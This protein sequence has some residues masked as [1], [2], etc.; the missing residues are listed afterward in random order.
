MTRYTR[1]PVL[2]RTVLASTISALMAGGAA[3]AQQPA[4]AA[5][6]ANVEEITVTGSRILRRDLNAPTPIM[7]VDAARLENSSTLS[8]E[9]VLNQMPQFVPE[10]TQFDQGIQA[11][12][13]ASLGIGSVNLRGIGAN[14]SLVLIDGRRA[15]PA[16]AALLVDTNSI[17]AAAIERVET[18]TGGA[19]AVY[20]A[21]AM[22]GVVNFILKKD[23]EGVDMDFHYTTTEQG[24]GAETRFTTLLGVNSDNHKGNVMLG[25]EWYDRSPVLLKDRDFYRNGWFDKGSDAGGF[26]QMPG[27]SPASAVLGVG[28]VNSGGLP[29][30]AAVDQIF[31]ANPT[32]YAGY[33]PCNGWAVDNGGGPNG[34]LDGKVDFTD[35]TRGAAAAGANRWTVSNGSEIYFNPDGTPF[36]LAGAHGYN[37]PIDTASQQNGKIGTGYAGVRL[38]PNGNLGQ[39]AYVGQA[40]SSQERHSLF[41]RATHELNDHLTAFAQANYASYQVNTTGGYPPAITVWS[42]PVP[43]DGRPIPAA[44]QTLLASRTNPTNPWTLYRVIDF[45]GDA[46]T[47]KSQNDVFQIMAGVDGTFSKR[48]W[49]WEAYVSSGETNTTNFYENMPSLQRYQN[50]I[51]AIPVSGGTVNPTTPPTG[52][53]APNSTWG[54][55]TFTSGRNYAQ[56]CTTGLP[57]FTNSS[58]AGAGEVSAD[59]VES[60]VAKTRSL[61]KVKQ[62]IAEFNLQGKITDMRAGELRFAA[63]MSTRKNEFSYD[64]GETN[65]RESVAENPMSIFASNNTAGQTKVNELYG[66]LLVPVAKRLEL[67]FGA[68]LSDYVD[69]D[70][71]TTNTWKS[72]FT[73]HTTDKFTVRGGLQ[74][75]ERAPNTAELFQGVSLL[76]VPFSPS[77]PCSFTTT[78]TWGNQPSN[79]NRVAVQNLCRQIINN[80][81]GDPSND[82]KS[83][84][85]DPARGGPSNFARPGNP[86]FPL[87]IE[88]RKGST[89]VPGNSLQ[90]ESGDTATLGVVMQINNNL[91]ASLDYYNVDITDAIAPLNSLFAY[92]QCFNANGSSNPT[93]TY[94]GSKYC[95]LI[96]RNV[97]SGERSS[98]DAPFI[99]TGSLKTDGIDVAVN[100]RHDLGKGQFYINSLMTFLGKY[101]I[102]DAPGTPVVHEKDTLQTQDGG[103]YKYKVT[104]Q[105]GY[106]F[107]GGKAGVALQWRYLPAIRDES[108]ART[109]TSNV[110]GVG[111]YQS[112]NLS[113]SYTLNEKINLRMGIDNLTDEQPPVVGARP[114][115]NNAE[116]TRADYYDILGRR[117]FVGVTARF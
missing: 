116:V 14:R 101:D 49:T 31:L 46:V 64:P 3:H 78:A 59:C 6:G 57:I 109:P 23:F 43:V 80:S 61:T 100:W 77:D 99:N 29:T 105:F 33:F 18:I 48:D 47:T 19:S 13:T 38:Q 21:D 24:D 39:V 40:Q 68:R 45:L 93:L 72:L 5:A 10:G 117:A 63:G 90:P 107:G 87:E 60:I 108:L 83:A 32:Q 41:G 27:Y 75:A 103:Q 111:S 7:T 94:A 15:Q 98:V 52:P 42:A 76:V 22:A 69:S 1:D 66:E 82:G 12:P 106:N 50:L 88:L 34:A 92:Q 2:N 84:F 20:G 4:A 26:I 95:A 54:R 25:I 51:N 9:S 16:N 71:G 81:D 110:F 112:F 17:P 91:S 74:H 85:D 115:D 86:F 11:G 44:L 58:N 62:N 56:T 114:G 37:G 35:C 79:P 97:Q 8:I 89:T 36:V 96:L 113:A 30:Q 65:D 73:W 55:G 104:N 53:G 67:E 102:Q 70:I 28:N